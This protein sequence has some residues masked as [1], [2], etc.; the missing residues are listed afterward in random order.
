MDTTGSAGSEGVNLMMTI[1]PMRTT[2][3]GAKR[4]TNKSVALG[5]LHNYFNNI[6][7]HSFILNGAPFAYRATNNIVGCMKLFYRH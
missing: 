4:P 3:A 6:I 1:A 7:V 2:A 5:H